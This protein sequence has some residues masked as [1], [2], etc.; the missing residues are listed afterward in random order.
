MSNQSLG[1]SM[2]I[3]RVPHLSEPQAP[4][5]WNM[6]LMF[7]CLIVLIPLGFLDQ[8]MIAGNP[9]WIKPIK[10][11][12][13]FGIYSL[14]LLWILQY[15]SNSKGFILKVSWAIAI[16]SIIE[17][18]AIFGQAARGIESHF[19][20]STPLNG[21]IFTIMGIS[22]GTFWIFH[23]LLSIK[24]VSQKSLQPFLKESLLWGLFISAYGMILGFFMTTPKPE[25]IELMQQGILQTNGG[26]TFGAADGGAG[27]Y[28]FGWSTIAGDLRIAHFFGMHAMQFF[29]LITIFFLGFDANKEIS[30]LSRL[31]L[32]FLGI[33]MLG[34]TVIMNIQALNG[35]SIFRTSPIYLGS[36]ALFSVIA[37][38][39]FVLFLIKTPLKTQLIV[40]EGK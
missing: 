34:I 35:E 31:P 18:I 30:N 27:I 20:I 13:S 37:I 36:Y 7:V 29:S 15:L 32:R 28:F 38:I 6:V 26:H 5:Y 23:L 2:S 39:G 33:A 11:A 9:I 14:T 4:L 17:I 1:E 40:S 10:F 12:L 25:Q 16:T 22:I 19:N 8:R 3:F 21:L 24:L